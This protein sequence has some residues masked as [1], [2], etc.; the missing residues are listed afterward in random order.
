MSEERVLKLRDKNLALKRTVRDQELQLKKLQTKL[1]RTEAEALTES[2]VDCPF[3]VSVSALR[4]PP[5][6]LDTVWQALLEHS[7]VEYHLVGAS[8]SAALRLIFQDV[9]EVCR[10]R[11]ALAT[12]ATLTA[13]GTAAWHAG[14]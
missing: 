11:A 2:L 6:G 12:A 8:S 10:P 9:S 3:T 14:P 13:E 5:Y 7:L 4:V 1:I